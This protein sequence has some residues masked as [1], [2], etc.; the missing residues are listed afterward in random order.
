MIRTFRHAELAKLWEH[1]RHLQFQMDIAKDVVKL[2][3]ILDA[4]ERPYDAD[5]AGIRFDRWDEN[6]RT[7]YG[8][9]LSERWLI[10]FFWDDKDA[11]DVDFETIN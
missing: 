8:I 2:L 6:K 4:A 5:F 3:D 7:R 1:G 9:T 10:S 11:T